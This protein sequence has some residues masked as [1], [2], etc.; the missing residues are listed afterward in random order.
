MT[1]VKLTLE[2]CRLCPRSRI[3]RYYTGDSFELCFIWKCAEHA[4]RTI[5]IM[6]W[7]EQDPPI[8]KWCPL[9]SEK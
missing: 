4:D 6:D 3:S 9:R 1:S 7:N 2:S 8:P 5:T